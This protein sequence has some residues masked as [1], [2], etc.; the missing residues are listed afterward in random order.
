MLKYYCYKTINNKIVVYVLIIIRIIIH[1]S[2]FNLLE[3]LYDKNNLIN[4]L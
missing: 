4:A 1:R 2:V 3:Y